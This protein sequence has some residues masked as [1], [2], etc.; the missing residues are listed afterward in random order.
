MAEFAD[1]LDAYL[2]R[3]P[4]PAPAV[5]PSVTAPPARSPESLAAQAFAGL[6]SDEATSLREEKSPARPKPE[7]PKPERPEGE[8]PRLPARTWI[9]AAAGA[10][11]AL[12]LG[13]IIYVA[14]DN[15][16]IRIEIDDPKA[17]V[18]V[19]GKDV[20]IEG[21]GEPITLRAGEHDYR[22][23]GAMASSRPISSSSGEESTRS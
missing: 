15:G 22:S 17:V 10:A 16:R 18:K 5:T 21:L 23:S 8:P 3:A 13:I 20:L 9:I 7:R 12:L 14:T 4:G 19:D 1:A 11:A 2:T 6:V